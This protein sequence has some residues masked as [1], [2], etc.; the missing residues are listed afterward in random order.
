[1]TRIQAS[2]TPTYFGSKSGMLTFL[3]FS[4]PVK[5]NALSSAEMSEQDCAPGALEAGGVDGA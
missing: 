2:F 3:L 4:Q 1:M 5:L